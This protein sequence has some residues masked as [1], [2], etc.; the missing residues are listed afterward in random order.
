MAKN[1]TL[2]GQQV[3]RNIRKALMARILIADDDRDI[4]ILT[5]ALLSS[6]EV[7]MAASVVEALDHLRMHPFD[8]VL[9]DASMPQLSGFDFLLTMKKNPIWKNIPFAMLTGKRDVADIQRAVRLGVQ[10]YIIKPLNPDVLIKKVESLLFNA[11]RPLKDIFESE[12]ETVQTELSGFGEITLRFEFV[13]ISEV[14]LTVL[15]PQYFDSESIVQI[16][17]PI[18][19]EI[20]LFGQEMRV[21]SS[22]PIEKETKEVWVTQMAYCNADE[23]TKSK[24]KIW[25]CENKKAS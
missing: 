14:G 8:L 6:H 16:E 24:L 20:G 19:R 3:T 1:E 11:P 4:L 7:T 13:K 25:I 23:T 5:Q 12:T 18:L 21:I 2:V 15:S 10:D 17:A 22:Y 9:S